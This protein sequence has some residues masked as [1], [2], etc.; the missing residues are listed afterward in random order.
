MTMLTLRD[1]KHADIS[2]F[3]TWQ[4]DPV[5]AHMAAFTAADPHDSEAAHAHWGKILANPATFN[6]TIVVD[7]RAIG[8]VL[9]F[10]Q[11]GITEVSYWVERDYW[12]RGI[13]TAALRGM[14]QRVSTRPL[15][16]RAVTDNL[17]SIRVLEKCG[18]EQVGT[19]S[20]F[21][22]ARQTTVDEYIFKLR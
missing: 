19:D 20:G 13:A 4:Q 16:A 22:N 11:N 3:M 7:D 6:Q 18:F 14:L 9:S 8:N 1:V 15:F 17:G 10:E 12:G 5:A 21:A 2:V